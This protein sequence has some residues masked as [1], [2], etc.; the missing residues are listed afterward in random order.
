MGQVESHIREL[1]AGKFTKKELKE[2]RDPADADREVEDV[3]DLTLGEYLRLLQEPKRWGKLGIKL[4]REK[5]TAE[6]DAVRDI[7]N[8]VMHFDPDGVGDE[9]LA[10]LRRFGLFLQRLRKLASDAS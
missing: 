9:A 8:D 4:D 1:I 3:A 6:L 5:F 10:T 2:A 7:R